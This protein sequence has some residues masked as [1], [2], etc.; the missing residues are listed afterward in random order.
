MEPKISWLLE[1]EPF[2]EYR[3]R[4]DLFNE[5][6]SASTQAL[7]ERMQ[8]EPG[9]QKLL[10]ETAQFPWTPLTSHKSSVHP[11][12]KLAFLADIGVTIQNP[13]MK[14]IAEHLMQ[15]P[16]E[17]GIYQVVMNIPKTY[18]GTGEASYSWALCD[19]PYLLYSLKNIGVAED[20]LIPGVQALLRE[21]KDFGFPCEVSKSLKGFRGPGKKTDPC[22]LVNLLMLKLLACFPQY[23]ENQAAKIAS[24]TLLNLWKNSL[25]LHPYMFFQGSDFRKLKLPTLWFDILHVAEVLSQFPW[26]RTDSRFVEMIET[27]LSK[28]Q[29][30]G[31]YVPESIWT[32][33]KEWEF[34]QKKIP[35][36]W[37]TFLITRIEKR[38]SFSNKPSIPPY[39]SILRE[40]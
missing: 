33:W 15:H 40:C 10:A 12:H 38:L 9:V 22:P 16:T 31:T 11:I 29:V 6:D 25:T 30:D 39:R 23:L 19:A 18:G 8:S 7:S 17:E 34:E 1:G 37:L 20:L 4:I 14:T 21:L 35:S 32:P 13:R 2:I 27:I 3:V 36:R 5:V 28:A 24:E 26:V